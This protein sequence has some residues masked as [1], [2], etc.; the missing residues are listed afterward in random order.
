M[1]YFRTRDLC[2]NNLGTLT[3]NTKFFNP[4]VILTFGPTNTPVSVSG[5]T[6]IPGNISGNTNT[7]VSVSGPTNNITSAAPADSSY[8][9]VNKSPKSSEN[10]CSTCGLIKAQHTWLEQ[11]NCWDITKLSRRE[12]IQAKITDFLYNEEILNENR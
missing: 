1:S 12:L 6:N 8:K 10:Y 3:S 9:V 5:P 2:S 11:K 7:H 4:T